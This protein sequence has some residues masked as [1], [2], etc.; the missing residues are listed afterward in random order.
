MGKISKQDEEYLIKILNQFGQEASDKFER[1][2]LQHGGK[3]WLKRGLIKE[4]KQE[5]IDQ[6]IYCTALEDQ[7]KGIKLGKLKDKDE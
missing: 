3:I 5:A 6:Y 4:M 7:L 2:C 1:G